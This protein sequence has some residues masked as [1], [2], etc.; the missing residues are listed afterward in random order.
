M[1]TECAS[2]IQTP[3]VAMNSPIINLLNAPFMLDSL[4]VERVYSPSVIAI[5]SLKSP[6]DLI[7][8]HV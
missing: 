1:S 5:P 6:E 3:I 8:A 2:E 4:Q 7:E